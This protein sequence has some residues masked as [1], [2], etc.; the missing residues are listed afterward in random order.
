MKKKKTFDEL[1]FT[2]DF[3]FCKV[4][5]TNLELCRKML[6]LILG[7]EISKVTVVKSQET[8]ELI[9]EA[10]GIRLDVTVRDVVETHYNVEMQIVK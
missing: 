6:E 10:K 2:D 8:I 7:K 5:T 1:T 4:L 9:R 3:M